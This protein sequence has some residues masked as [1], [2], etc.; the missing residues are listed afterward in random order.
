MD[1]K[2][3]K[4]TRYQNIYKNIKNGNYIVQISNPKTTISK[5]K[6]NNKIFDINLAKDIRDN[7][8]NHIIKTQQI[9]NKDNF[10]N[11]YLSYI[12]ECKKKLAYNTYHKKEKLYKAHFKNYFDDLKVSK[13]LKSD[14]VQFINNVQTTNL[15]KNILLKELRAFFNWCIKKEVIYLN[16]LI[17][18]DYFKIE[19][20][21]MKYWTPEHLKKILDYLNNNI[22][23]NLKKEKS[24][25]IKI[26]ILLG[27]NTGLRIGELRALNFND[28]D[29]DYKTI[30]IVHSIEYAP[31]NTNLIK[32][33]KNVYSKR[34]VNIS[35]KLLNELLD[36]KK[37]LI[38]KYNINDDSFLFMNH[39]N[40][41][42]YSDTVLRKYFN[43]FI[44]KAGVPK[45]R[46]YDLR[47]SY[48]TSMM[49]L[50]YEIYA[51]S[52]NI[53]HNDIRTTSN[54]YGHLS[55][56]LRKEMANSTDNFY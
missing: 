39:K 27:F 14:I 36:Y 49:N 54:V 21:E 9:N 26:L 40:N 38:D 43:E 7:K 48:V 1:K 33:T 34:I 3:Y 13:I 16:P 10:E 41:K 46:M 15:Q 19:K 17:S 5:D 52:K 4:K 35:D 56:N 42:I 12:K 50:G 45:I 53:G 2:R 23:N 25:I 51:I 47:H 32:D 31:N 22:K 18:I 55:E 6:N 8:S 24:Y 37:Y 11:L 28:I 20:Q 44:E 30:K 29:M